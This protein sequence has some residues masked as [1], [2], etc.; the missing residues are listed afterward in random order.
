MSVTRNKKGRFS[1]KTKVLHKSD[2][3]AHQNQLQVQIETFGKLF[4][5]STE[6]LKLKI[7]QKVK[8]TVQLVKDYGLIAA[9][10]G[11]GDLTG[12]IVNEQKSSGKH[13]KVGSVLEC[14]VLDIDM[15]KMIVDLSE[16]LAESKEKEAPQGNQKAVVELNKEQYLIVTFKKA[17]N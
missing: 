3:S 14:I 8:A 11:F 5:A 4:K 13:Y 6:H 7:G 17:R 10:E 12:F 1:L 2:S 9:I 16:R 15:S